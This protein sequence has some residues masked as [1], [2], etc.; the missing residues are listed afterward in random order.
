M[1]FRRIVMF[2]CIWVLGLQTG[3][4][5]SIWKHGE[6]K[7]TA[8][9][10]YLE[11]SDGTPFFWLGDTAWELFHRLKTEDIRTYLDNRQKK[12]FNVIQAVIIP[13]KNGLHIP[14][15]YGQLP[16][17]DV[18]A[19]RPNSGYFKLI[20]T[21]VQMAAARNMLMALLPAWGDNISSERPFF[22]VASAY[23]YGKF[24]G[25]RYKKSS[26]VIWVLGGDYPAYTVRHD[27]RPAWRAM[28]K[29]IEDGAGKAVLMS[30]HPG[31]TMWES[32]LQVHNESWL[33]FNMIQSGH[34]EIDQPVWNTVTR[35]FN[36]KPVKPVIDAEPAY[37]DHPVHP[38]PEWNPSNGYFRD[39]EVR[40]QLYRS[41]FSGAFGV[42]Y[43]HH[44]I[45]QFYSPKY[46]KINHADRYWYDA[47]NRPGAYQAGYLRKL[48]ESRPFLTRVS[49]QSIILEGQGEKG[50]YMTAFRDTARSYLMVYLPVG[51]RIVISGTAL[52]GK[53]LK[54]WW[55]NPKTGK[56]LS[57]GTKNKLTEMEFTP[58]VTGPGNDWVLVLDT[59]GMH[60]T[61]PG[62]MAGQ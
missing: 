2:T 6:L 22:N 48:I 41:V 7:V 62:K 31:G 25:D 23:T 13:T 4:T 15:A 29:G 53:K 46:E 61:T 1:N 26:N 8:D 56:A 37:E 40:K 47:L 30:F 51:K 12:G 57:A 21:V 20:D 52:P 27:W 16:L 58:P 19:S 38:W 60:F 49:D 28:A 34:S 39:Y 33:D 43:G 42:T 54:T 35:D 55:F 9:D 36:L 44:A 59:E 24:L 10:H 45:W 3:F 18:D 11:H 17:T 14:N 50:E 5:Q 32:A